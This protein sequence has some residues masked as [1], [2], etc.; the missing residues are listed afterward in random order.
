MKPLDIDVILDDIFL[1]IWQTC[2]L[3]LT[4]LPHLDIFIWQVVNPL[5]IIFRYVT[6]V[7]I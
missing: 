6:L 5:T 2:A 4:E 1:P 7:Q 3:G